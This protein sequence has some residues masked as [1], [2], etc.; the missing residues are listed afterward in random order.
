MPGVGGNGEDG[1]ELLS[2]EHA[3]KL[4]EDFRR[5]G[6]HDPCRQIPRA[7]LSAEHI[8]EYVTATGMIAPLYAGKR[9]K[10]ASYQGRIGENAYE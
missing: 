10:K 2:R 9:M 3:R 1:L 7:L 8:M 6:G 5:R 4:A